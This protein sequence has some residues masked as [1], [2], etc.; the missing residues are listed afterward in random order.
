MKTAS[1]LTQD[2]QNAYDQFIKLVID[3]PIAK[4]Q[5]KAIEGTGGKVSVTD[6]I[7]YQIGWSRCLIRWYEAGIKGEQPEMPGEGF[8][9]WDYVEIAKHFYQK[10][11][12]DASSQQLKVFHETVSQILEIT[13]KEQQTGNLDQEGIWPWCTLS[14]GKKWPLSKWIRIN[15]VSPYKRA[16]QLIKKAALA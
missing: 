5:V 9:K 15:I 12:Y 11:G 16:S 10:Y 7:A 1:P 13:Q 3:I 8:S 14:S 6:L 4:R 2:I